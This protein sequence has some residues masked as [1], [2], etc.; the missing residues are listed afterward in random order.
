LNES[1][2]TLNPEVDSVCNEAIE[3]FDKAKQEERSEHDNA[4]NH[5]NKKKREIVVEFAEHLEHLISQKDI[6]SSIIVKTMKKRVSKS[7]IH[8][9]LPAKYKQEHRRNNAFKQKKKKNIKEE[10]KLAPLVALNPQKE[11]A[12]KKKPK[13]E[14]MAGTDGR[15]YIQREG[16]GKTS[17]N[18]PKDYPD[19]SSKDNTSNQASTTASQQTEQER[20]SID[21]EDRFDN[22]LARQ[23]LDNINDQNIEQEDIL[24]KPIP[25]KDTLNRE[26]ITE[27]AS[28]ENDKDILPFELFWTFKELRHYFAPLLSIIGENGRVWFSGI[29]NKNTGKVISQ[30]F[31]RLNRLDQQPHQKHDDESI[32]SNSRDATDDL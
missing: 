13:V 21:N 16:D 32:D 23:K 3:K 27:E 28:V 7:L 19:S 30:H 18:E 25:L 10:L 20:Q 9:C 31:G 12:E 11:E 5:M 17:D 1:D 4:R 6:I 2:E 29:I 8:V 24:E 22:E 15:S 14:V 26:I